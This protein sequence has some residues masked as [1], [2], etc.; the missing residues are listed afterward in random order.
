MPRKPPAPQQGILDPIEIG[1]VELFSGMVRMLGLPPSIGAIYGLLYVSVAPLSLDDL[2][3]KLGISKGSASQ[4]L[5]VLKKLGALRPAEMSGRREY[6]SA[7]VAL[8]KLVGGF[9]RSEVMPNLDRGGASAAD[10]L[11][12]V[13]SLDDT[14]KKA[15]LQERVE[16]L[17]S[18]QKRGRQIL[19]LLHRFL[20]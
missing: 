3:E 7:D 6:Y 20:D 8:K 19:G 17:I 5:A 2:V 18:W 16:R 12:K 13:K 14:G 4:G 1:V 15:F 10:L 11:A 9:L